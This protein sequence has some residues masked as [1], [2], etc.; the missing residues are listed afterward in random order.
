MLQA[1]D[2]ASGQPLTAPMDVSP[3]FVSNLV[4]VSRDGS[5]V[6][7]Q[8]SS[9][10]HVASLDCEVEI[11]V[12]DVVDGGGLLGRIIRRGGSLRPVSSPR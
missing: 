12:W 7:T 9:C 3:A 2:A 1:S 11:A 8:A 4:M 10:F 5:R 6:A